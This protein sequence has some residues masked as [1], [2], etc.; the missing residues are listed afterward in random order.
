MLGT[1]ASEFPNRISCDFRYRSGLSILLISPA[2]PMDLLCV[3]Q[4]KTRTSQTSTTF[5]ERSATGNRFMMDSLPMQMTE[6]KA[7]D[8]QEVEVEKGQAAIYS[9]AK[10]RWPYRQ[11]SVLSHVWDG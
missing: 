11:L 2:Y 6:V 7:F 4:S 5:W 8:R 9:R 1:N 10:M 3:D